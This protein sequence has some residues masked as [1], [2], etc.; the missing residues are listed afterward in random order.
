MALREEHGFGDPPLGPESE[1]FL[2]GRSDQ[3]LRH[4]LPRDAHTRGRCVA[5]PS[6]WLMWRVVH[7]VRYKRVEGRLSPTGNILRITGL[8]TALSGCVHLGP[9]D[10][11][12]RVVG[13][14]PSHAT[15]VV[16]V[17]AVGRRV[18]TSERPVSAAFRESFVVNP[19]RG[20]HRAVLTCDG[21][22]AAERTFRLGRDVRPGGDVVLPTGAFPP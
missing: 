11:P 13:A 18:D 21:V 5:R 16:G 19:S 22:I 14:A 10:A 12:V 7:D 20:G 9:M 6:R 8:V 4:E 1:R 2:A 15:C 3:R 17:A